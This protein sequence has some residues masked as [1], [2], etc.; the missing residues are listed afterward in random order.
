MPDQIGNIL[1]PEVSPSGAL[2]LTVQF[3]LVTVI[4]PKIAVHTF[5]AG[6]AKREQRFYLGDPARR[7]KI[8]QEVNEAER[9]ALRDFWELRQ[10][11]YQPFAF[12]LPLEDG[13]IGA[14]TVAFA[15]EPL[16]WDFTTTRT[17]RI[18]VTL[19]EVATGA[20][21][22]YTLNDS[23]T[24]SDIA[25]WN[26]N[27]R[28]AGVE[29]LLADALLEQA[30]TLIPLVHIVPR[31]AGYPDNIYLCDRRCTIGSQLYLPRLLWDRSGGIGQA[32]VGLP[33]V[34]PE[35][36][37][38]TLV[39]GNADR[40]MRDLAAD[41][42]LDLARVEFSVFHAETGIRLELWA[43]EIVP[44]GWQSN[45]GPE[46]VVKC[47]DPLASP[48][49]VAPDRTVGRKCPKAYDDGSECP[50][51]LLAR[52]NDTTHFPLVDDAFCDRGYE[53][54]NGCL[55][56]GMKD[57]FGGVIAVPQAV[58]VKDNST[59]FFGLGRSTITS[60]SLVADSVYGVPLAE[61][62]TD[63]DMRVPAL[64]VAGRDEG[65]F[66]EALGI[67][68][69]GPL[70]LYGLGH[71]LDEQL[72]HGHPGRFGLREVLGTDPAGAT[73]FLS[74]D[75]SG[76]Q[77]N[78]DWRKVFSGN[79]TYLDNFSAGVAFVV[80]R[81]SDEK[82]LQL[83][84]LDQHSMEV[85]VKWGLGGWTWSAPGARA[86]TQPL[87]NPVWVA[88][89]RYLRTLGL[90]NASAAAQE[91]VFDVRAAI[92][93][94]N[95]C[96]EVVSKIV[97]DGSEFQFK[98]IGRID[99]VRPLRDWLNDILLN[100]LGY[101]TFSFGKLKLGVRNNS[102]AVAAFTS[103][104][105]LWRSLRLESHGAEFNRLTMSFAD[106]LQDESTGGNQFVTNTATF[107]DDDYARELGGDTRAVYRNAEMNLAGTANISQAQRI[108]NTLGREE[109]GGVTAEER[110]K[111]RR[112]SWATTILALDVEAGDVVSVT[113]DEIPGGSGEFRIER[114]K[115]NPDW[116][117]ELQG[118][119]V[120]DS[121]YDLVA[122]PKPAD[123][124]PGAVP[125]EQFP[126]PLR[127]RWFPDYE[128]PP[129]DDA[130]L[131]ENDRTFGIAQ[132]YET[133]ADRKRC[134]VAVRG[135]LPVNAF[136]ANAQPPIVRG[137]S[138]SSSGGPGAWG[139]GYSYRRAIT[140]DHTQVPAD[141]TNFPVLISGAYSYLATVANGG[142]L[143]SAS[144]YDVT[145][146]A[147]AEGTSP[148]DWEVESWNS[149][150]GAVNYW[151]RVPSLSSATDTVIYIF[152]GNASVS[153]DQSDPEGAWS[154]D[155]RLVLHLPNGSSLS[156]DDSTTNN[157]SVANANATAVAGKID[158]GA[159]FNGTNAK[160]TVTALDVGNGGQFCTVEFWAN[161]T[162]ANDNDTAFDGTAGFTGTGSVVCVP[163]SS[164]GAFSMGLQDGAGAS[165]T[166]AF[167]RPSSGM[168]HYMLVYDLST[169][170]AATA[171]KLYVDGVAQTLNS[172]PNPGL[173]TGNFNARTFVIMSRSASLF[174]AGTLDEF[175]V[176]SVVKP[177]AWAA[178]SFAN[179]DAPASFYSIGSEEVPEVG[180]GLAGERNYWFVLYARD[181]EGRFSPGSNI[182]PVS[183]EDETG[184]GF[185]VTLEGIEWPAG[186]WTHWV[187]FAGT[188]D[189]TICFQQEASPAE[190][191]V[192]I[193]F[194][195]PLK[196][197][198]YNM[199]S[200]V[201][202][203]VVV[204]V[205]REIHGGP[206]GTA[207]T[208]VAGATVICGG[209]AGTKDDWTGRLV[210][211]AADETDG[212]A[213]PRHFLITAYDA[214]TGAMTLAPDPTGLIEPGDVLIIRF[215]ADTITA[216]TIGD[217]ML[218]NGIY[219]DGAIPGA[220]IGNLIRILAGPGRGNRPRR[221]V[222]NTA[223]VYTIDEPWDPADM[224]T[225]DSIWIVEAPEWQRFA[226]STPAVVPRA[227]VTT[228]IRAVVDNL[229]QQPVVVGAFLVDRQFGE[230]AEE[231]S[232]V[233]DLWLYG[234]F[235]SGAVPD[236]D[237]PG[238]PVFGATVDQPGFL[239]L[240]AIGFEDLEN[241]ATIS[242][243][244]FTVWSYDETAPIDTELASAIDDDDTSMTAA[245]LGSF[246]EGSLVL[247][248]T[249]IARIV[250]KVGDAA[251]IERAQMNSLAA[252][253]DVGAAI[254]LLAP[255][256][257]VYGVPP[258][259]FGESGDAGEWEAREP[260]R[261]H[262]V[263]AVEFWVT[264]FHGD[265]PVRTGIFTYTLVD[266]R[267]RVLSGG[268]LE[269]VVEGILGIESN[270]VPEVRLPQSTSVRDI[271]AHCDDA[272]I[273]DDIVVRV[274][275]DGEEYAIVSIADGTT[276]PATVADGKDLPAVPAD[277]PVTVDVLGVGSTFPGR[278][279]VVR[280]RF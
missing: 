149:T 141:L 51:T 217:S 108:A 259:F 267:L 131:D 33:G 89:N 280:V 79:S 264:N 185:A 81:R 173:I 192:T 73:D 113:D 85:V 240:A 67:V 189:K 214:E 261:C 146:T 42:Q 34:N 276:I 226:A 37:D 177:A 250:S 187:L 92:Y 8:D 219:P 76:N 13:S 171:F 152:Y 246:A 241:T 134:V 166:G 30:Q 25:D 19:I 66:Y 271:F 193:E 208:E 44:G 106:V 12:N 274:N 142:K 36:D 154:S 218:A 220:E 169:G 126:Q 162:F 237:V 125:P 205:K 248:G 39:F 212:S 164:S 70:G 95:I 158:G 194:S 236:T 71:T 211:W 127:S 50:K 206:I 199:P 251:T 122:G 109:V 200:P 97:G 272:P 159:S 57:H 83:T 27:G 239:T 172:N 48:Y 182:V 229:I 9:E 3:G 165:R 225:A 47:S 52:P 183:L 74:L 135:S 23:V 170:T 100:C 256:A 102:S 253:H 117:I 112:A 168:H 63:I 139:N 96:D 157:H 180:S 2:P 56:L 132:E 107:Q 179:Q 190:L 175:R 156:V 238:L 6:N 31:Q 115:L 38:V 244:N 133:I 209:L 147:D 11:A 270:A 101:Y 227:G 247:I 16:A 191:P 10:G 258:N 59:G 129:E 22:A 234:E 197:A 104:N 64:I 245:D 128:A 136:V 54:P 15:S 178:A 223:T 198:T 145:F 167:T 265:S 24:L 252:L 124:V 144:G 235:G 243:L 111:A 210:Y 114:W 60:V 130:V 174:M 62:Y 278:R 123:V 119:T 138:V 155:Y 121:M 28:G 65:D 242:A 118:R 26:R 137:V 140:I 78:G 82:G 21:P 98:F 262:A 4:E 20:G 110:R 203:H 230:N 87:T 72:H 69:E 46:F 249:E 88:V 40:V 233:R 7:F 279:L 41:V 176:S 181:A 202:R 68:G 61:I 77:T 120:T 94:A 84:R 161:F 1:V 55:A 75:Q 58:R 222:T 93:A 277:T 80:I 148:L 49:M 268:Q 255:R 163:N 269:L 150:T 215:Q 53:T 188:S 254:T 32:A 195:G 257:L 275:I 14:V 221:I 232:P 116:S 43:G 90:K 160:L 45:V 151:V 213:P 184:D 103:G 17:S 207:V 196:L 224:P 91:A 153:T 105:M 99:T 266:G 201:H 216:T 5:G 228:E 231:I 273:G 263:C 35:S 29:A 86:A 18:S 260:F 143:E 204:K 186:D